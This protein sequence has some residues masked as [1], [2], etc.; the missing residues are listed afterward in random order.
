MMH[1]GLIGVRRSF[2]TFTNAITNA[3][4]LQISHC[5]ADGHSGVL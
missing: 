5:S 2:V 3:E 4:A 1:W